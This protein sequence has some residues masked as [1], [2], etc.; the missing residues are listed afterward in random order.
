MHKIEEDGP[1]TL[2]VSIN[3]SILYELMEIGISVVPLATR[4]SGES[5]YPDLESAI[6]KI[7]R[8]IILKN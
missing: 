2:A 1:P 8:A 7:N 3:S 5:S 4:V 6:G